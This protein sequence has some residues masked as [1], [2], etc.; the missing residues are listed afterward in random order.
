MTFDAKTTI[1]T[2]FIQTRDV[3][4]IRPTFEADFRRCFDDHTCGQPDD[5][6][7]DAVFK[8]LETEPF[9]SGPPV[10]WLWGVV[11]DECQKHKRITPDTIDA[12]LEAIEN[13]DAILAIERPDRLDPDKHDLD[14]EWFYRRL[15]LRH[16]IG[17]WFGDR[18]V[19][20]RTLVDLLV[21]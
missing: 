20:W 5:E 4:L 13:R 8:R 3:R 19:D 6:F 2:L 16:Q 9:T 1:I 12:I 15:L 11:S 17:E 18:R 10:N 7:I 14:D 21:A